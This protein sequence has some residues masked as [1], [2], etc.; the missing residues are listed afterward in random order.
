[1]SYPAR[2][3]GLDKYDKDIIFRGLSNLQKTYLSSQKA[4]YE[5]SAD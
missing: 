3:E 1:M 2:A 4:F 5:L